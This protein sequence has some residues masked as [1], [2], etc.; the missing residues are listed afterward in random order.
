VIAIY[1]VVAADQGLPFSFAPPRPDHD[2]G[3]NHQRTKLRFGGAAS[4]TNLVHAVF[5]QRDPSSAL[6]SRGK[7]LNCPRSTTAGLIGGGWGHWNII[8]PL[9]VRGE[10]LATGRG[11]LTYT[12]TAYSSSC[13]HLEKGFKYLTRPLPCM[14]SLELMLHPPYI[15]NSMRLKRWKKNPPKTKKLN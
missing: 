14:Q 3:T 13:L 5:V 6:L 11:T 2:P 4:R 9:F 12:F 7:Y 1:G 10:I 15:A 8:S